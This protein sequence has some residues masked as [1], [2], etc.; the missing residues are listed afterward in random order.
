MKN[1]ILLN[2]SNNVLNISVVDNNWLNK[3]C[4][5]YENWNKATTSWIKIK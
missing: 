4:L 1:F 3:I 5:K 2:K